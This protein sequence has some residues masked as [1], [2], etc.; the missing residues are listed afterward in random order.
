MINY[1]IE[2][3][4]LEHYTPLF[5]IKVYGE[6]Y[7]FEFQHSHPSPLDNPEPRYTTC[8]I[9]RLG[10]DDHWYFMQI[11]VF[12]CSLRDQFSRSLGRRIAF[13]RAVKLFWGDH[14]HYYKLVLGSYPKGHA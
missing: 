6:T 9:A 13:G 5:T 7:G 11:G 12:V 2:E 4:K 10:K 1:K 3:G 8:R 14:K